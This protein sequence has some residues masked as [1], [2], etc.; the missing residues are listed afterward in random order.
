MREKLRGQPGGGGDSAP[1]CV[2][3]GTGCEVRSLCILEHRLGRSYSP[4]AA[5]AAPLC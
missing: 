3:L 2:L 5:A 1:V 4:A